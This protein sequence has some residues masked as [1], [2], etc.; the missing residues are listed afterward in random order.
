MGDDSH[1]LAPRDCLISRFPELEVAKAVRD[2][3]GQLEADLRKI[4]SPK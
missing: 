3:L 2:A 4:N 1:F